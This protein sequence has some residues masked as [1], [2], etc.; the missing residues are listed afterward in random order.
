MRTTPY[1]YIVSAAEWSWYDETLD[2]RWDCTVDYR[3]F[4]T[5]G[6]VADGTVAPSQWIMTRGG[7]SWGGPCPFEA[8]LHP[9][10]LN[11]FSFVAFREG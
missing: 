9:K 3:S 11:S 1:P 10:W 8:E 5:D 6:I 2:T 4:H 7:L